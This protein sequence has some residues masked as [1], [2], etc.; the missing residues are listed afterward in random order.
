MVTILFARGQA[1]P[2]F[3]D[4]IPP[5]PDG[6]EHFSL[7]REGVA[8]E[9]ARGSHDGRFTAA[10]EGIGQLFQSNARRQGGAPLRDCLA[11]IMLALHQ[12]CIA[13]FDHSGEADILQGV[14]VGAID[15][16]VIGQGGKFGQRCVHLL[17]RAFEQAAAAA[18]KQGVATKQA[19]YSIIG[20]VAGS[21]AGH[22]KHTECGFQA[23][24]V[25]QIA[26]AGRMGDAGNGLAAR[27]V[28]RGIEAPPQFGGAT[29]MV[30]VVVGEQDGV[31]P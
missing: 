17:R 28:N 15:L 10:Q 8:G 2:K 6:G 25:D 14:F 12:G 7:L 18:G 19:V 16:G 21:V 4:P 27:A 5:L 11:F 22:V 31:E 29:G 13:G 24:E 20:D 1:H 9:S 30:C 26:L 23:G 3:S